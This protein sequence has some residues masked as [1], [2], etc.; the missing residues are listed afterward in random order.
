MARI[1]T[2]LPWHFPAL[3]LLT[4]AANGATAQE[5]GQRVAV[6][7][8]QAPIRAGSAT[9]NLVDRGE[10]L[11]VLNTKESWLLVSRGHAGWIEAR[12]VLPLEKGSKR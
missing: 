5:I 3:L 10:V 9:I 11:T 1:H 2:F 8:D 4:L 12:Q 7:E 6:I